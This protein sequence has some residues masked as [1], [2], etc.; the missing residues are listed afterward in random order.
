MLPKA[1]IQLPLPPR[2][3]SVS[4]ASQG[5]PGPKN[6]L[7]YKVGNTPNP[8]Q[9]MQY[10]SPNPEP[11][12]HEHL[13]VTLD[14]V[15]WERDE[16]NNPDFWRYG[17]TIAYEKLQEEVEQETARKKICILNHDT[18][19]R[20]CD[21][22]GIEK[23][24]VEMKRGLIEPLTCLLRYGLMNAQNPNVHS[25][26]SHVRTDA[27]MRLNDAISAKSLLPKIKTE[28]WLNY[29]NR[30]AQNLSRENL[31]T[32]ALMVLRKCF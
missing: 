14:E 12:A 10:F 4:E 32:A 9:S 1:A 15:K 7:S 26:T 31:N 20:V 3:R 22:L 24:V 8:R 28:V 21:A 30:H 5:Q 6:A 13:S 11:K 17:S 16:L 18:F 29:F 27:F 2:S 19:V 25:M 23:A